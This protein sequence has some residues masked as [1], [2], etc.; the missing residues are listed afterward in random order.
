MWNPIDAMSQRMF[1]ICMKCFENEKYKAELSKCVQ[2]EIQSSRNRS[3]TSLM[4][5]DSLTRGNV[6]LQAR[7]ASSGY[8]TYGNVTIT[9][10]QPLDNGNIV[11]K[12]KN[13]INYS[14]PVG[15]HINRGPTKYR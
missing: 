14:A 3:A 2:T 13:K 1:E 15:D 6:N 11:K 4:N 5:Y 8:S 12:M 9:G 7:L 10:N